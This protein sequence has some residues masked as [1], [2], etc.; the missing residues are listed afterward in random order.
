MGAGGLQAMVKSGLS[1]TGK[2]VIVAGS[3]PLLLAV[4]VMAIAF[5]GELIFGT[6]IVFWLVGLLATASLANEAEI[7]SYVMT[8]SMTF[9][10]SSLRLRYA[11]VPLPSRAMLSSR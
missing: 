2:R 3:G 6:S 10:A 11:A 5:A 1:I 4:A 9:S 8:E 7:F